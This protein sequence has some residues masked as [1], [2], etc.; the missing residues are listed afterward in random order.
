MASEWQIYRQNSLHTFL[1]G[2]KSNY[3]KLLKLAQRIIW[4]Y[5]VTMIKT[6]DA[7]MNKGASFK[8][9]RI[10]VYINIGDKM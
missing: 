3:H 4:E 10:Y 7:L 6:S 5:H 8:L 1:L 9:S 2:L